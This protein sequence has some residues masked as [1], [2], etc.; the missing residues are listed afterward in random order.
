M[1]HL[2]EFIKFVDCLFAIIY[3][4]KFGQIPTKKLRSVVLLHLQKLFF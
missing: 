1:V 4:I 3:N 2:K